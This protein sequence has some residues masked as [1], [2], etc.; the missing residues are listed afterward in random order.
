MRKKR[1]GVK[2]DSVVEARPV[3]TAE[4]KILSLLK[5]LYAVPRGGVG[6]QTEKICF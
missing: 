1:L 6:M 2:N 5:F 4:S 3:T